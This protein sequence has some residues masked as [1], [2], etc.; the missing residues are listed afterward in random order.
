MREQ[1]TADQLGQAQATWYVSSSRLLASSAFQTPADEIVGSTVRS[2]FWNMRI[3][4][5]FQMA[6]ALAIEVTE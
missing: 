1:A 4:G 3:S 5:P 6:I 2:A